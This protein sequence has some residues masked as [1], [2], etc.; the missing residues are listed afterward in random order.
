M[1]RNKTKL[2]IYTVVDVW[3]GMA[4]GVRNFR[5]LKN[6]QQHVRRLKQHRNLLQ[7]D[8]RLFETVVALAA[9]QGRP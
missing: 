8:V 4:V 6:A 7:D 9:R 2:K 3:R 1:T 5:R